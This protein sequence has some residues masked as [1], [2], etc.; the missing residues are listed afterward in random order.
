MT[1]SIIVESIEKRLA[2]GQYEPLQRAALDYIVSGKEAHRRHIPMLNAADFNY[3]QQ[4]RDTELKLLPGPGDLDDPARRLVEVLVR[5]AQYFELAR[6]LKPTM[7]ADAG[8]DCQAILVEAFSGAGRDTAELIE[9]VIDRF[10]MERPD[11][12]PTSAGRWLLAQ[13]DE[14]LLRGVRRTHISAGD[15]LTALVELLRRRRPEQLEVVGPAIV[16]RPA[17]QIHER[18]CL[19]LLDATGDRYTE[20]LFGTW[21]AIDTPS[22][23]G[24]KRTPA[25]ARMFH[26]DDVATKVDLGFTFARV[27]PKVFQKPVHEYTMSVLKD[28]SPA[29]EPS[30][31]RSIATIAIKQGNPEYIEALKAWIA[32]PQRCGPVLKAMV[33]NA[34][35]EAAPVLRAALDLPVPQLR[36]PAAARLVDLGLEVDAVQRTIQTELAGPAPLAGFVVIAGKW[37]TREFVD[38]LWKL[39]G[40]KS[41]PVREAAFRGLSRLGEDAVPRALKLLTARRVSERDGAVRILLGSAS[42]EVR[43]AL[44]AHAETETD[45]SV[46]DRILLALDSTGEPPTMAVLRKRMKRALD[47]IASLPA[48]WIDLREYPPLHWKDGSRLD[49]MAVRYLLYRQSRAK[50]MVADVEAR[51]VYARVDK[52]TSGNF[53]LSFLNHF[54]GIS[55]LADDRWALALAALLGDDRLV[56][57]LNRQIAEWA[58]NSRGKMAEYAVSAMALM[59]SDAALS[60]VNVLSI[61]YSTQFR[62]VGKAAAEAFQAA[63][64]AQGISADE[65]G[66]RV[67]PSF[68]L[69]RTEKVGGKEFE[70][71][72]DLDGKLAIRDVAAKKKVAAL[73]KAASAKAA[74]EIKELKASLKEAWKGQVSRLEGLMV[75]QT[76][77]PV[78]RWKELYLGH[79]I[80]F[81]FSVCL[82]W[83][84]YDKAILKATFRAIEDRTLTTAGDD[85][86]SLPE[87]GTVGIV[88]PLELTPELCGQWAKHLADYAVSPPFPQLAR[89]VVRVSGDQAGERQFS[90]VEDTAL[91]ALTFRGRAEK[92][93]WQRGSVCD[94]GGIR[95]Y[96]KP[97][98]AAGTEALVELEDM[99]V[100]AG[101]DATITLG[102]AFFVRLGSVATGSYV[103]DEPESMDD[104]RVLSFR[105]VPPIAFSEALGDLRRI[106]G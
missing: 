90:E 54:L 105:D 63:A 15:G 71:G 38:S 84:W 13:S 75:R 67:V 100:G 88:H 36:L 29:F 70:V 89:P 10:P 53:A 2:S 9:A 79:P 40:N 66:D 19:A 37:R 87:T 59:G 72:V 103:Y 32:H 45:D 92:L 48:P 46:R 58:R 97:F 14:D 7:L 25:E 78:A 52:A 47:K 27:R 22:R 5:L 96:R 26:D 42:P 34:G 65:L 33:E 11:G 31:L 49:E 18:A 82:V 85:E 28:L 56:P 21:G 83:G 77:W 95:F 99:Y 6:W 61:R 41:N 39:L 57:V 24:P 12:E 17:D 94:G 23:V 104:R 1:V 80:L 73:P 60:A 43:Q 86:F 30:A 91:N 20:L 68:G 16:A 69:P 50:E 4:L 93:G 74:G 101:M 35:A 44:E 62:N 64:E 106:A 51:A 8:E 81:P 76:R 102:K 3:S 55:Q 98:P